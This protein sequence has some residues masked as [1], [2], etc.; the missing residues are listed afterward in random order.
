MLVIFNFD[1]T[2][3]VFHSIDH[4]CNIGC[5]R[6]ICIPGPFQ[7]AYASSWSIVATMGGSGCKIFFDMIWSHEDYTPWPAVQVCSFDNLAQILSDSYVADCI[8]HEN[9]IKQ[10]VEAHRAH[11][12]LDMI[13]FWINL[14]ADIK[15][16]C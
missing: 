11:I 16:V 6:W 9:Y 8:M 13:T 14:A 15:H 4:G 12:T 7:V 2:Q 3:I 10:L 5:I 1:L